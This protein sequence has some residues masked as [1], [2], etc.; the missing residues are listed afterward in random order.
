M[1]DVLMCTS[2]YTGENVNSIKSHHDGEFM[3][4]S[5]SCEEKFKADATVKLKLAVMEII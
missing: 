5:S 2:Q 4:I 1:G 3:D